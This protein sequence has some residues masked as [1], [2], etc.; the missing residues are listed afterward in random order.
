MSEKRKKIFWALRL[1][2]SVGAFVFA[3]LQV[4]GIWDKANFIAI[5]LLVTS[6]VLQAVQE[7]KQ[8]KGVAVF[9]IIAAILVLGCTAYMMTL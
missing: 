1:I 7:W 6:L 5:A 2:S 8:H 4:M 3:L 9:S